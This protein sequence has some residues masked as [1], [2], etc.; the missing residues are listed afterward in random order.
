MKEWTIELHNRIPIGFAIGWSF[1]GQDEDFNYSDL[2]LFLGLFSL[3][4][5]WH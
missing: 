5:K 4:F 3:S 2:T 1:Y